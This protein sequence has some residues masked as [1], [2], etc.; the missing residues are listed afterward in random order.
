MFV[1]I[2]DKS[3]ILFNKA[4]KSY[5]LEVIQNKK[6]YDRYVDDFCIKNTSQTPDRLNKYGTVV[7]SPEK[8]CVKNRV[9]NLLNTRPD[10]VHKYFSNKNFTYEDYKR[11][12]VE[13]DTTH[14]IQKQNVNLI[15]IKGEGNDKLF[16]LDG[17]SDKVSKQ[18]LYGFLPKIYTNTESDIKD[19]LNLIKEFILDC[20]NE[21]GNRQL[22]VRV[23][24]Y[25]IKSKVI[26]ALNNKSK[27]LAWDD[28]FNGEIKPSDPNL[29]ANPDNTSRSILGSKSKKTQDQL[30]CIQI[31]YSKIG[32]KFIA[33]IV[34]EDLE[35]MNPYKKI[36]S[37]P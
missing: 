10:L 36:D 30:L 7:R 26:M 8:N 25:L 12:I 5:R 21:G 28:F 20:Y 4:F 1:V 11:M 32:L 16:F 9:Q 15:E 35:K 33:E 22:G 34:G 3:Y 24:G 27:Q 6:L 2:R 29:L 31:I 17:I 37:F 18:L 19:Q 14:P 13:Y 23:F